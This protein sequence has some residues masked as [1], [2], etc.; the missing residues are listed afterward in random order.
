M[1]GAHAAPALRDVHRLFHGGTVAG[2]SD[3]ELLG[4]FLASR[5]AV[6][7]EALVIRHGPGVLAS[8]RAILGDD[9]A[10]EDAFQA[11]FL[12]LVRKAPSI[13]VDGSLGRWLRGVSRRVAVRVAK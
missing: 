13:R 9:P 6:A 2:L 7:F 11:V 4:R 3:E 10:V 8:C 5:D 12:V 1:R